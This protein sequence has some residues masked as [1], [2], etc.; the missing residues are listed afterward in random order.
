MIGKDKQGFESPGEAADRAEELAAQGDERGALV[1]LEA[2]VGRWPDH[3]GLWHNLGIAQQEMAS[4]NDSLGSLTRAIELGY[5]SFVS[6]GLSNEQLGHTE[7]ARADYLKALEISPNDA[8][9]LVNLGTLELES[10][11]PSVAIELLTKAAQIDPTSNWQ[12]ADAELAL[13]RRDDAIAALSRAI[14]AGEARAYLD[15]AELLAEADSESL[16]AEAVGD[17]RAAIKAGVPWARRQ[18]AIFLD[19]NGRTDEARAVAF[20]GIAMGD[21]SCFAPLAVIEEASGNFAVA[22]EY[23]RRALEFGDTAYQST[24]ESLIDK[25]GSTEADEG[26]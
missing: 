8:N 12:L 4:W 18:Y 6:R 5:R 17:Y 13:G 14:S 16:L 26:A 2:A 9:A 7:L 1:V 15:R 25:H 23:Y 11:R 24:L 3:P 20:E 22:I 10:N 19:T 21:S